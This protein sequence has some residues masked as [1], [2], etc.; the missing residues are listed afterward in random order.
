MKY[1]GIGSKGATLLG[2]A[3]KTNETLESLNLR[4]FFPAEFISDD[5]N[6]FRL[7]YAGNNILNDTWEDQAEIKISTHEIGRSIANQSNSA[8]GCECILFLVF[9]LQKH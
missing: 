3:L 1:N 8:V 9:S 6:C 2:E 5:L 7:E 4:V